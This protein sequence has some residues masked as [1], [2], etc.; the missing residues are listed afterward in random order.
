MY[1]NLPPGSYELSLIAQAFWEPRTLKVLVNGTQVGQALSI[2]SDQLRE[3]KVLI[4]ASLVS[5]A[6]LLV[7]T[8]DYDKGV[9]PIDVGQGTDTRKLAVMVDK[10]TFRRVGP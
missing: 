4:P 5:Q 8:L 9:A 1:L 2:Q 3:Y 10:L 7:L 6:K